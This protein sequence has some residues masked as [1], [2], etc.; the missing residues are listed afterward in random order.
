MFNLRAILMWIMHD[1]LRY[2]DVSKY[3]VQG[4]YACPIY[5]PKFQT[6]YSACLKKMVYE[7]QKKFL[8]LDH[9]IQG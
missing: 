5:G 7:G 9:R 3:S 8:L 6:H 4:H 1:Y 2:G